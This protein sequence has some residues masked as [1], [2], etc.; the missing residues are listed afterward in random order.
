MA[1]VGEPA[2]RVVLVD[3]VA[4]VD[5]EVEIIGC[6]RSV[7][8]PVA[9]LIILA[10]GQREAQRR[11]GGAGGRCGAGPADR[12]AHRAG[13]EPVEVHPG[14]LQTADVDMHG[15]RQPRDGVLRPHRHNLGEPV[16][17]G[18]LPVNRDVAV[19]KRHAGGGLRH[20]PR[21]EDH[22]VGQRV[23][24]GDPEAE[25]AVADTGNRGRGRQ[26]RTRGGARAGGSAIGA[27]RRGQQ[28]GTA[29]EK[30]TSGRH[31]RPG[32]STRN[33]HNTG[34]LAG[35]HPGPK[36]RH[37][38]KWGETQD[39]G[40]RL[41]WSTAVADRGRQTGSGSNGG[42]GWA[43]KAGCTV[44]DQSSDREPLRACTR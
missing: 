11:R 33:A 31:P 6:D 23:A 5:D 16:I 26:R 4:D 21:P 19:G 12:A 14:R 35:R 20:Q 39:G 13:A 10:A 8:R 32:T 3:V 38:H 28:H 29:R 2:L 34:T 24:A 40:P 18:D 43:E 44:C 36:G 1:A 27:A 30:A 22:P 7:R 41:S 42:T 37:S 9:V 17:G 15:V 25:H